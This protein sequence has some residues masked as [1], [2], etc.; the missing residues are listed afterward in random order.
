MDLEPPRKSPSHYSTGFG[1]N[2]R[3]S[4]SSLPLTQNSDQSPQRCCFLICRVGIKIVDPP[5]TGGFLD[6]IGWGLI[7][8]DWCSYKKRT[9]GHTKSNQGYLG[10]E[11]EPCKNTEK[12]HLFVSQGAM[13]QKKPNLLTT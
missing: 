7:Q 5:T 9:F 3:A 2:P 4:F 10:R 13:S 1:A 6:I 8:A 12:R 11:E